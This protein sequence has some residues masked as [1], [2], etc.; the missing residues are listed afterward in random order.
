MS[1]EY[2][3]DEI[4]AWRKAAT[5]SHSL[6]GPRSIMFVCYPT[7][8]IGGSLMTPPRAPSR[9]LVHPYPANVLP[10]LMEIVM[11]KNL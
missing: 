2:R 3:E 1:L 6:A 7:A 11:V 10:I 9:P 8:R 4:S 5:M